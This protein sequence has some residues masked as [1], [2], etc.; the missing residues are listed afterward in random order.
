VF[1]SADADADMNGDNFVDFAD[2]TLFSG[3]FFQAPG[4][5]C[6]GIPLP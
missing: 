2:L 5:S 4:P 3:A 6:C 1:F